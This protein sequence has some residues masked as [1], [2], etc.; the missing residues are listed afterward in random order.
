MQRVFSI[1]SILYNDPD[2]KLEDSTDQNLEYSKD[3]RQIIKNK[4]YPRKIDFDRIPQCGCAKC[5]DTDSNLDM[6][7]YSRKI[8]II[9]GKS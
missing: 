9:K 4:P 5:V 7:S 8:G 1:D 6:G 2:M 3:E